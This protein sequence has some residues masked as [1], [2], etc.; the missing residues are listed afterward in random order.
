MLK[1]LVASLAATVSIALAQDAAGTEPCIGLFSVLPSSSDV[2][3]L[4]VTFRENVR[5]FSA[6]QLS[7][8]GF[9]PDQNRFALQV[10]EPTK[11]STD[12]RV[13]FINVAIPEEETGVQFLVLSVAD[14][15]VFNSES[16][17]ALCGSNSIVVG[18]WGAEKATERQWMNQ[19]PLNPGLNFVDSGPLRF[20][21]PTQMF[22]PFLR[23]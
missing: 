10:S 5:S 3:T 16:G 12:P 21:Q 9:K 15:V 17:D 13:F 14:N 6:E 4:A 19:M 11:S 7:A 20:I 18:I 1:Q 22:P 8:D 23:A 2:I